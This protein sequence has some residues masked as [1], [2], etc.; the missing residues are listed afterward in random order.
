M[1]A[2]LDHKMTEAQE[3]ALAELP[4]WARLRMQALEE[5]N[6]KLAERLAIAQR[7]SQHD[8]VSGLPNHRAA[9]A[10][11]QRTVR[12]HTR[13]N[14]P[15]AVFFI[16]GDNLKRYNDEGYEA[17]NRMIT[18]LAHTIQEGLRPTDYVA[19]WLS[20]DEFLAV[21]PEADTESAVVVA[22]RLRK[23][24]EDEFHG[25]RIPVTVSIGVAVYPQDGTTAGTLID[26]AVASNATA[27]KAGKNRV[28]LAAASDH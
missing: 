6:H 26:R 10:Q 7:L 3:K 21:L 11:L 22:E 27:K 15:F 14:Q 1:N 24:V 18:R 12:R 23:A 25:A 5:A 19:R 4:E 16:D 20:G 9:Q 13:S 8:D 17:G 2:L 28:A